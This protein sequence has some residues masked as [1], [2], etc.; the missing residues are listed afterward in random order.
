[1]KRGVPNAWLH[2]QL[3][4]FQRLSR[5]HF[6]SLSL[7]V[8]LE[9]LLEACRPSIPFI[10]K[11]N[12]PTPISTITPVPPPADMVARRFLQAWQD[13]DYDT[14]Y[15]LLSQ[16]ARNKIDKDAFA[17]RYR[18][19]QK[20][21]TVTG[22][23]PRL[24]SVGSPEGGEVEA[25]FELLLETRLVGEVKHD[26]VLHL[27]LEA[28]KWRVDWSPSAIFGP[29][30]EENLVHLFPRSSTRGQI[31]DQHGEALAREGAVVTVG[32]VPGKIENETAMLGVLT[33]ILPLSAAEIREKYVDAP[34]Q[35]FI[36]VGDI[37]YKDSQAHLDE[38]ANTPG[39]SFQ[40]KALRE[41]PQHTTAAHL[42]GY[43][44]AISGEELARLGSEG[45]VEGDRIGK[46]GL[47]QWGEK[48]LAGTKGG[49]LAVIS[50]EG[51]VVATLKD[52]PAIQSRSLVTALDLPL[53][54]KVEEIL[55]TNKGAI[56]VMDPRDG[57]IL[58]MASRPTFDPNDLINPLNP[59]R[60]QAVLTMPGQ[61]LLNRAS[62]GTYPAGSIFKVVSMAAALEKGGFVS[63]SPFFC[64]GVWTKLGIPMY[65]WLRSGHGNIDLFQGLI[66]SCDVVFYE[67]GLTLNNLD[68]DILPTMARAFG[69]GQESG[70]WGADEAAGL[71]PDDAW[72]I[73]TQGYGWTPGDT[74]NMAVGQGF[75]LV[76]PLQI[77]VLFSAI[78]NGGTR[79]RPRLVLRAESSVGDPPIEFA[80][81]A[82]GTLPVSSAHL[83]LIRDALRRVTMGPRG[84]ARFAFQGFPIAVAGKTGTAQNAGKEPHAWFVGY[85]PADAPEIVV[86]ALLENAGEGSVEAA[87]RVRKVLEAYFGISPQPAS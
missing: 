79:Y 65:C 46:M 50:P 55:G 15:G 37:S 58:A 85:A 57:R 39:I 64:S 16:G 8:T 51:Q 21:A 71:V 81:E 87:P 45:Y 86:V 63:G 41:Y 20:E 33:A 38:L 70:L 1:M 44:D 12:T 84:T 40:Q 10:G 68:I 62:Q 3:P 73:R 36:P 67:V 13:A 75:L 22:I 29:L 14:M 18:A 78:A 54:R 43:V 61:P 11:Q 23:R 17:S 56:V 80:P 77:A 32:V 19:I 69:L 25:A 66:Q 49:L 27:R 28:G 5:R 60:R 83:N 35:W 42:V 53:Q 31:Y 24:T 59:G 82:M 4:R 48:Y 9:A 52:Q 26:N 7:V 72:K 6:L 47:E 30:G 2:H 74:V 76:T 34:P